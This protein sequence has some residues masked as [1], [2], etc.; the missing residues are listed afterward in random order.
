MDKQISMPFT[1][2]ALLFC[3]C[4]V[5]DSFME[6]KVISIYGIHIT[7]GLALITI[8]YIVSDCIVEVYGYAKARQ[9][10]WMTF[11]VHLFV[12]TALQIACWLPPADFWEGE[13]HFQ[14][15]FNLTPRI[16]IVSMIAFIV[17][18]S[19]NA[20]VMSKMKILQNGKG[21]KLRAFISTVA[22][23]YVDSITF[24]PLAFYGLMPNNEILAMIFVQANVKI[25]YELTI[26]PITNKVV[27]YVKKYD[28]MDTYDNN[29]SYN[30]FAL[31]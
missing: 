3:M 11:A 22:G 9:V 23:E 2:L 25:L 16:T 13:Q 24:F 1:I 31:R 8:S 27:D 6:L 14:Y 29:I 30:I 28:E 18:S 19:T 10:M 5:I 21:F 7:A 12:V 26:L 20:Y 17:G 15:I 4:F